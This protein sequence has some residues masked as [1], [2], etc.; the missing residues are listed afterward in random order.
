MIQKAPA[1]LLLFGEYTILSGSNALALPL[2]EFYGEWTH[3][4]PENGQIEKLQGRLRE[5]ANDPELQALEYMDFEAMLHDID[6]GRW[7][8]SNIPSGYGLGSSGVV[9]ALIYDTYCTKPAQQVQELRARLAKLESFF[10][11]SSSGIDPLTSYLAQPLFIQGRTQEPHLAELKEKRPYYIYLLD[12]KRK[13]NTA[14]LVAEFKH[15][16]VSNRLEKSVLEALS[17]INEAAIAAFLTEQGG[18]AEFLPKIKLLSQLQYQHLNKPWIPTDL[19]QI[20]EQ[21]LTSD[22]YY[23]KLCGAG[24]GGFFLAFSNQQLGKELDGFQ[25]IDTEI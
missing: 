21:G 22:Q 18:G 17:E 11:G 24:G 16:V 19:Q 15:Q 3:E 12:S 7:I 9:T 10:H 8:R 2:F 25:L 23:L 20:W 6:Q 5:L 13:R 1:K 14:Q 4:L